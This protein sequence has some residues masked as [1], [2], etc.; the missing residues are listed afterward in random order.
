MVITDADIG[1][2]LA[3]ANA[4]NQKRKLIIAWGILQLVF[5]KRILTNN[6]QALPAPRTPVSALE[7][8]V[9]QR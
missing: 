8:A 3:Y 6:I 5:L 7:D 4:Q 2:L 9:T 1:I